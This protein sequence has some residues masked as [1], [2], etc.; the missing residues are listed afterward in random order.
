[1]EEYLI[2][3]KRYDPEKKEESQQQSFGVQGAKGEKITYGLNE[4]QK[5]YDPSM[6]YI[7]GCKTGHCGLCSMMINGKPKLACM[8]NLDQES[9]LE[10]LK[11]LPV[12]KDLVIDRDDVFQNIGECIRKISDQCG[13][14]P[15][16]LE[17]KLQAAPE[18]FLDKTGCLLCLCCLS[19]CPAGKKSDQTLYLPLE[20]LLLDM[21]SFS[22]LK[23]RDKGRNALEAAGLMECTDCKKCQRACTRGIDI[24]DRIIKPMKAYFSS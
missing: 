8:E 14:Q 10:A 18:A 7:I 17:E 23:D 21:M 4:I 5:K 1:M 12:V 16:Y 20:F 11:G 6:S 9:E 15:F 24:Y 13:F 22:D 2:K 19:V 3:I